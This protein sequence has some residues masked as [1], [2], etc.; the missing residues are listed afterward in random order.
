MPVLDGSLLFYKEPPVAD[1]GKEIQTVLGSS[2]NFNNSEKS[3][4]WVHSEQPELKQTF[5]GCFENNLQQLSWFQ[6]QL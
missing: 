5:S 6:F 3:D 4:P 2:F 1:L